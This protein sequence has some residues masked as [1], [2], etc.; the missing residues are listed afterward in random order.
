[1]ISKAEIFYENIESYHKKVRDIIVLIVNFYKNYNIDTDGKAYRAMRFKDGKIVETNFTNLN[2]KTKEKIEKWLS[3][4]HKIELIDSIYKLDIED[5][6]FL[7]KIFNFEEKGEEIFAGYI[8]EES[9]ELRS[10]I[11]N[12]RTN[13]IQNRV[14]RVLAVL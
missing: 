4:G 11:F 9:Y 7:F 13:E 8:L 6:V 14:N 12:F 2:N 5:K 1:M 10:H 3:S